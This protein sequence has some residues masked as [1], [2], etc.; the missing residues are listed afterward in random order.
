MRDLAIGCVVMEDS[1]K[2]DHNGRRNGHSNHA[3]SNGHNGHMT[4]EGDLNT[5][6]IRYP[7]I[8]EIKSAIPA[9]CFQPNLLDSFYYAFKDIL[10][11][12][13]LYGIFLALD[14]IPY[15]C[16]RVGYIPVYAFLQGTTFW[17]I[18]VVGHDCGHGSFSKS[19]WINNAVGNVLHSVLLVPF[20]PWKLSH[21][22]HHQNTGNIDKDEIFYPV[23]KKDWGHDFTP[24]RPAF[25]FGL[26][27]FAYLFL[28]YNPRK[29]CHFNPSEDLFERHKAK[30]IIS[31]ACFGAWMY[32]LLNYAFYQGPVA[33]ML[34]YVFP[35]FVFASWLVIVTFL[36]HNEEGVAWYADHKWSYVKGQLST[37]DRHYGWAHEFTHN[38]GT[39]Q[40]HHLFYR[41]PHYKLEEATDHFRRNFPHLVRTSEQP[42]LKSFL[43]VF[44]L[45]E[46]QRHIA[47]ETE[48][49]IYRSHT[50]N[51]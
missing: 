25:G 7:S 31:L 23:R 20:Y 22:H 32:V 1:L 15:T 40:I 37:V 50:T 16:L 34:H 51:D 28:G 12:L 33:L 17:A 3:G 29:H 14:H 36:H 18:F 11:S 35:L 19:P 6:G 30:C 4:P 24:I 48:V 39:H 43:R 27:W 44:E 47:D 21:H 8:L 9:H 10:I 49:H 2:N 41:I 45:F 42:I 5:E 13:A 26:G 38:I 46:S